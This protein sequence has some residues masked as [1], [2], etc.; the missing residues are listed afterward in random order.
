MNN[1]ANPSWYELYRL[2]KL[3]VFGHWAKRGLVIRKNVM[4]LDTGCV[5]GNQLTAVVLPEKTLF[6]VPAKQ[7]YEAVQ[8]RM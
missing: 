5:Y 4:G 3:V 1:P 6:Q 2:S 7:I 8:D